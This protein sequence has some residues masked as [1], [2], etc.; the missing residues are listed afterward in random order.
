MNEKDMESGPCAPSKMSLVGKRIVVMQGHVP[1]AVHDTLDNAMADIGKR[2]ADALL[3]WYNT[4]GQ[5][6]YFMAIDR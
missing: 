3:E 2:A 6:L 1:V 4:P 5:A